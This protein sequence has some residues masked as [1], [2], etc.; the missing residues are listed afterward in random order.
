LG[1]YP[2]WRLLLSNSFEERRYTW[3]TGDVTNEFYSGN[4]VI[5]DG[6]F[7]WTVKESKQ[8]FISRAWSN[9]NWNFTDF[10][11]SVDA[12]EVSGPPTDC[13]GLNFRDDG[14]QNYYVFEVCGNQYHVNSHSTDW[15]TLLGPKV[16]NVI[17]PGQINKLAIAG[18]GNH[19]ELYINNQL[20]DTFDD[21]QYVSGYI[22][23]AIEAN[24][25][26][27]PTFEF[28][29]FVVAQP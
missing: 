2:E 13:Y 20:V 5:N 8:D 26:D 27:T 9:N 4:E 18:R 1:P 21:N 19:F 11:M 23:V 22:G 7:V 6:K 10:Y 25:G 12:Q 16:A 14:N 24:V 29:N 15:K 28:N 17:T 3:D